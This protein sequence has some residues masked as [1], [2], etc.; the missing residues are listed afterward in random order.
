[1]SPR[2]VNGKS[3]IAF[4]GRDERGTFDIFTVEPNSGEL[5][6]L[7]E[8]RG[9]NTHPSWAPNGRAITYKSSRGGIY[10][11]TFDGKTERPVYRGSADSPCWGPLKK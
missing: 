7:T 8:N 2:P 9:S 1:M 5:L 3:V 10:A 6:R 11:A 4:S